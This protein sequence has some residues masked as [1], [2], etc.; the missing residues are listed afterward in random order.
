MFGFDP[1]IFPFIGGLNGDDMD[2]Y[3]QE[4]YEDVDP[5]GGYDDLEDD[6]DEE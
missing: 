2:P 1:P 4:G 3:A 5:I 6:E